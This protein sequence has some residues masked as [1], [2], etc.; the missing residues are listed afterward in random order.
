M[1]RGGGV[2]RPVGGESSKKLFAIVLWCKLSPETTFRGE[3]SPAAF[4]LVNKKPCI[5]KQHINLTAEIFIIINNA[6]WKELRNCLVWTGIQTSDLK[7]HMPST[8]S[9]KIIF[10]GLRYTGACECIHCGCYGFFSHFFVTKNHFSCHW[11]AG[12]NWIHTRHGSPHVHILHFGQRSRLSTGLRGWRSKQ[13]AALFAG[14]K[15]TCLKTSR[16]GRWG[17]LFLCLRCFQCELFLFFP[18]SLCIG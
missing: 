10:Y 17:G 5:Y 1:K 11:A 8:A 16:R 13:F 15:K 14:N 2:G 4:S 7:G 12:V 9:L 3:I 6:K 18:D